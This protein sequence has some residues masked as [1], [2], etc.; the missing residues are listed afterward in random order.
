[1]RSWVHLVWCALAVASCAGEALRPGVGPQTPADWRLRTRTL[2][3]EAATALA[4]ATE[5]LWLARCAPGCTLTQWRLRDLTRTG[6]FS[7]ATPDPELRLH[8]IGDTIVVQTRHAVITL[9]AATGQ[10]VARWQDD[11]RYNYAAIREVDGALYASFD[12]DAVGDLSGVRLIDA[13]TGVLVPVSG[14]PPSR[15][16]RVE[17]DGG[18]AYALTRATGE[19]LTSP[20]L[21]RREFDLWGA[22]VG[23]VAVLVRRA[24]ARTLEVELLP[25]PDGSLA[26]PGD[27]AAQS[28]L[29]DAGVAVWIGTRIENHPLFFLVDKRSRVVRGAVVPSLGHTCPG[30]AVASGGPA[31]LAVLEHDASCNPVVRITTLE[32][33]AR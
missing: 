26:L 30:A 22:T 31:G 29:F 23:D 6:M 12:A 4:I 33:P 11:Q 19:E 5:H 10:E 2:H 28:D 25:G 3:G 16:V 1:M 27:R 7:V 9:A 8:A 32:L 21:T 24:T 15:L 17:G 14:L 20:W 13:R 18:V